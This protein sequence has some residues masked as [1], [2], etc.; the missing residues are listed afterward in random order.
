MD[1][2]DRLLQ[3]ISDVAEVPSFS[4][5]EERLHPY[6]YSVYSSDAHFEEI[7]VEGNNI[8]FCANNNAS[9]TIALAAH[10]DKINH[11]GTSYPDK[12]PVTISEE[13]IEGVMD[14][15]VGV[16][17][18]LSLTKYLS[19]LEKY[20]YLL[21]FSEMEESKG[22]KEHPDLLKNNGCGYSQGM[23]AKRIAQ[24]CLATNNIPDIV[25]TIDTTPLFKGDPGLALYAKHWDLNELEPSKKLIQKTE[26]TVAH[27]KELQPRIKLSNNTNDYLH[28]GFEF[29][30]ETSHDVV[31]VA[32][33]P[34]IYPYHQKSEKV[35]LDDIWHTY[36]M[37][38]KYLAP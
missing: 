22:L 11:F 12:L 7:A 31:S 13:Y 26:Q 15:S 3:I 9:K 8:C 38:K 18:L 36:T 33:E 23:G 1:D 37:L 4:S 34:A 28:Y 10:I 16:G 35:F 27:F 20:N 30:H 14:D 21:F 17:I 25:I 19:A 5:Y 32:L 29:N 24:R 6:I 2:F